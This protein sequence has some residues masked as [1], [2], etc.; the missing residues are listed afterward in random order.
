MQIL[1]QSPS[2]L[3]GNFSQIDMIN[4]SRE[5]VTAQLDDNLDYSKVIEAVNIGVKYRPPKIGIEFYLKNDKKF[6][7]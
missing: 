4:T 7:Q 3:S 1:E 6:D 2:Q 5:I